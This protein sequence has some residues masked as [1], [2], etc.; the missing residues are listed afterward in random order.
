MVRLGNIAVIP[1][2]IACHTGAF[3]I[4][5]FQDARPLHVI[6]RTSAIEGLTARACELHKRLPLLPPPATS[7]TTDITESL[8]ILLGHVSFLPSHCPPSVALFP[9]FRRLLVETHGAGLVF[10]CKCAGAHSL[11]SV[12]QASTM[13]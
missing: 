13:R 12:L 8:W 2:G 7:S 5:P 9:L 4:K 11:C 6:V 10:W 3:D 1:T